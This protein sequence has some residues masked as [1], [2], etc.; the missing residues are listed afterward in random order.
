MSTFLN[1]ANGTAW[2]LEG[3]IPSALVLVSDHLFLSLLE[4]FW[5]LSLIL[6]MYLSGTCTL[7]GLLLLVSVA[8]FLS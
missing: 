1:K 4:T 2:T 8:C 3:A 5:T 6:F 7:S